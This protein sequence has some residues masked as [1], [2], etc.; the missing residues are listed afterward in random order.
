[1]ELL[2]A[3]LD[4]PVLEVPFLLPDLRRADALQR[5]PRGWDA[6]AVARPDEAVDGE[7]R[8]L[9]DARCAEKSAGQA[10]DVLARAVKLNLAGAALRARAKALCT[11][12]VVRSA[13]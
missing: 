9:A 7:L 8:V 12:D 11:P 6:W 13:A 3:L 10:R 5:G 2:D 1:M 4:A